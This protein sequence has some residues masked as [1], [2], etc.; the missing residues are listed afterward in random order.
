MTREQLFTRMSNMVQMIPV[1][2]GELITAEDRIEVFK[3]YKA[4]FFTQLA[5]IAKDWNDS[6]GRKVPNP[7]EFLP[8]LRVLAKGLNFCAIARGLG[9][10][11]PYWIARIKSTVAI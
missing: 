9:E 6:E 3:V 8:N 5:K 7:A 11:R 4:L 2:N 1:Q 10:S